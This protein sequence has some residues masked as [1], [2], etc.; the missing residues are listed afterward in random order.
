[1]PTKALA[2]STAAT[3]FVVPFLYGANHAGPRIAY[4]VVVT[5]LFVAHV[6]VSRRL[7]RRVWPSGPAAW[8]VLAAVVLAAAS[9]VPLPTGV[10]H[11]LS[12]EAWRW[13]VASLR[14]AGVP[15]PGVRAWSVAPV[16]GA[17]AFATGAA[18]AMLFAVAA[19][20]AGRVADGRRLLAAVIGAAVLVGILAILQDLS[21]AG[22]I[23]WIGLE[24]AQFYGAFVNGNHT[25]TFLAA[26]AAASLALGLAR[27]ED[28]PIPHQVYL[29]AAAFCAVAVLYSLSR[30]GIIALTVGLLAVLAAATAKRRMKTAVPVPPLAVAPALAVLIVPLLYFVWLGPSTVA[31][32]VATLGTLNVPEDYRTLVW[33]DSMQVVKHFWLLGVGPGG[34]PSVFPSFRTFV[35]GVRAQSAESELVQVFVELG[36]TGACALVGAWVLVVVQAARGLR[37]RTSL[38]VAA[39]AA[40]LVVGVHSVVDFPLHTVAVAAAAAAAAGVVL[41]RTAEPT[42]R[43]GPWAWLALPAATGVAVAVWLASPLAR[44]PV[45]PDD[46]PPAHADVVARDRLIS[47]VRA[48]PGRFLAWVDLASVAE[49]LDDTERDALDPARLYALAQARN[50]TEPYAIEAR[51]RYLARHGALAEAESVYGHLFETLE[52]LSP[53]KASA[54]RWDAAYRLGDGALWTGETALARTWFE[55]ALELDARHPARPLQ[56]LGDAALVEGDGALA[57]RY[58]LDAAAAYRSAPHPLDATARTR[59]LRTL[60]QLAAQARAN[61]DAATATAWLAVAARCESDLKT[62]VQ[63]QQRALGEDAVPLVAF[64]AHQNWLEKNRGQPGQEILLSHEPTP[65]GEVLDV[66]YRTLRADYE[67]WSTHLDASLDPSISFRL[68]LRAPAQPGAQLVAVVDGHEMFGG[69]ARPLSPGRWELTWPDLGRRARAAPGSDRAPHITQLG[70]N[71]RGRAGRYVFER[72]DA[73]PL[74]D[75]P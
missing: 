67:I 49:R 68:Q 40:F 4:I 64:G 51:A 33:K 75:T 48:D 63:R 28:A 43:P 54:A 69:Q 56:G 25:A 32:E 16:T 20:V 31:R 22:R 10:L 14:D 71:T 60:F 2:W 15:V 12:P 42:G 55:R 19:G 24:R 7:Q 70:F 6:L 26:A 30:G 59:F 38:P 34:F 45:R 39:G 8:L 29:G 41:G 9:L 36:V 17:L 57:L 3:L 21:D 53:S 66:Q 72:L 52:V 44:G 23:Y 65:E 47:Q 27:E 62:A 1:M 61:G 13:S 74:E 58:Y 5:G 46:R 73:I 18:H 35:A 37:A 50:P 11:L